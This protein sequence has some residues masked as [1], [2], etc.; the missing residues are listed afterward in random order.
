M[1]QT[2]NIRRKVCVQFGKL[3]SQFTEKEKAD[4]EKKGWRFVPCMNF[5]DCGKID[6]VSCAKAEC[7][8]KKN[9]LKNI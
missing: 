5:K 6:C 9:K 8:I 3:L 7:M 4:A 2:N 1:K